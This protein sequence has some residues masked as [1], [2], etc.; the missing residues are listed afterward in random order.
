MGMT[1]SQFTNV[2][3]PRLHSFIF[4]LHPGHCAVRLPSKEQGKLSSAVSVE[5]H[6]RSGAEKCG[7]RFLARLLC[8][9]S[10]ELLNNLGKLKAANV[11]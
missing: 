5:C 9:R 3:S 1:F 6:V 2:A 8:R 4:F 11:R 10:T 7:C